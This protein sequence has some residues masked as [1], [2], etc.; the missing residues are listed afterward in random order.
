MLTTLSALYTALKKLNYNC[1]HMSECC[2]DAKNDSL[3]LWHEAIDAKFKNR[4]RKYAGK[5]FDKMLWRYDVTR[6]ALL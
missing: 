5:D 1:Y 3:K 2:L 6:P 4:G